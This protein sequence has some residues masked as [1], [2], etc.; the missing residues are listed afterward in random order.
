MPSQLNPFVSDV[1]DA[2]GLR[3]R[4]DGSGIEILSDDVV[5]G[6]GASPAEAVGAVFATHPQVAAKNAQALHFAAA[7]SYGPEELFDA[8]EALWGEDDDPDGKDD[9]GIDD[10]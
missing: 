1:F 8:V 5:V 3:I 9:P 6:T 4:K 2:A 10:D 7:L